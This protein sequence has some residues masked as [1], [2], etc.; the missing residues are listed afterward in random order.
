M[1]DDVDMEAPSI[2]T[3]PEEKSPPPIRL[4]VESARKKKLKASAPAAP[5]LW[6]KSSGKVSDAEVG[7]GEPE[8][9]QDQLIDDEDDVAT[10]APTPTSA[11]GKASD[12]TPK[13]K[14]SAKRKARKEDAEGEG[15]KRRKK[16][17]SLGA[18][19]R[20]PSGSDSM[21][22]ESFDDGTDLGT[23]TNTPSIS[24]VES[25]PQDNPV[26]KVTKRKSTPRKT[27]VRAAKGRP[28]GRVD[29]V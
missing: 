8:D 25:E 1:D 17:P 15:A 2:S 13:K 18:I 5:F 16:D 14:A 10:P 11:S 20:K 22:L 28:S 23:G 3:L 19:P 29:V 24:I 21:L 9:E 27:A 4:R 6:R 7:G 26:S 12:A